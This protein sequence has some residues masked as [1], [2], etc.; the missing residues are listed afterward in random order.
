MNYDDI[1][2]ILRYV[3]QFRGQTFVVAAN[4]KFELLATNIAT[5]A[6]MA[7]SSLGVV[8]ALAQRQAIQCACL[9]TVLKLP[10]STITLVEDV[11]MAAMAAA[12][13]LA[14]PH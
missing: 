7:F 3:P 5:I 13:L 8:Q 9:G 1:R 14:A 12:M 6:L 2:G 4:P 11:G 10:M